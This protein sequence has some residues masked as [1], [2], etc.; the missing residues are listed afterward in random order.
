MNPHWLKRSTASYVIK[1]RCWS[2]SRVEVFAHRPKWIRAG[3]PNAFPLSPAHVSTS[4]PYVRVT[5]ASKT[6]HNRSARPRITRIPFYSIVSR[7]IYI[8]LF[9]SLIE[10]YDAVFPW[11]RFVDQTLL[12]F[13]SQQHH[14][15]IR[16]R[17]NYDEQKAVVVKHRYKVCQLN[18]RRASIA[19]S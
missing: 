1:T 5:V 13:C 8:F 18:A 16:R 10:R 9:L 15:H 2:K 4:R 17:R 6:C 11:L 14:V 3:F 12:T 19:E 7:V